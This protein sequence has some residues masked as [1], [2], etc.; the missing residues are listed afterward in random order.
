M[1]KTHVVVIIPPEPIEHELEDLMLKLNSRYHASK[2]LL[3]KPHVTL[4]SLGIISDK[5]FIEAGGEIGEA[6]W[7]VEPF[8]LEMEG[9]R[10]YGSNE[11]FPG[12]YIPVQK[13]SQLLDLHTR[14]ATNLKPFCDKKDRSYKEFENYNPHLTLVGNDISPEDLE[15]AKRELKNVNYSYSFPVDRIVF[16]RHTEGRA[17]LSPNWELMIG[18]GRS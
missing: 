6:T 17:S 2:A 12:V 13:S 8:P 1:A 11:N 7:Y 9:L 16:V 10:F 18:L 14:L 15:R 4:K 3:H 5:R